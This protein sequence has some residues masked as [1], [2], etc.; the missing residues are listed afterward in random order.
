[1]EMQVARYT[2]DLSITDSFDSIK[3]NLRNK[4]NTDHEGSFSYYHIYVRMI[5]H[6]VLCH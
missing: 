3:G 6:P 4:S 2:N 1:M 5:L